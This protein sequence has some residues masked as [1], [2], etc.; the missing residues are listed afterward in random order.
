MCRLHVGCLLLSQGMACVL[1]FTYC[2]LWLSPDAGVA[3]SSHVA[4]CTTACDSLGRPVKG[5][6]HSSEHVQIQVKYGCRDF[7]S[8]VPQGSSVNDRSGLT[9]CLSQ[10]A[11]DA[12]TSV[13]HQ[14]LDRGDVQN[15]LWR[16]T[17]FNSAVCGTEYIQPPAAWQVLC[18]NNSLCARL[19]VHLK[20][21]A[22][23]LQHRSNTCL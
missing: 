16:C 5:Q 4:S 11:N 19:I 1:Q 22:I 2:Y 14:L 13:T 20:A 18:D 3:A 7:W 23:P 21:R 15:R 9:P 6:V 12:I 8:A 17:H 10:L